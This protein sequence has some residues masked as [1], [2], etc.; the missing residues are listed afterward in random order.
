VEGTT[1][2]IAWSAATAVATGRTIAVMPEVRNR[3]VHYNTLSHVQLTIGA[4]RNTTDSALWASG[5]VDQ[6]KRL[7]RKWSIGKSW[8]EYAAVD[9][10][11]HTALLYPSI[12]QAPVPSFSISTSPYLCIFRM[13]DSDFQIKIC[14]SPTMFASDIWLMLDTCIDM[15]T[16][17]G[18]P[19]KRNN[20]I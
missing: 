8:P 13:N 6:L 19:A 15:S 2:Q 16:S 5:D 18:S 12:H 17:T 9:R 7:Q 4:D 20:E 3:D 11:Q 14:V 10:S 1:E